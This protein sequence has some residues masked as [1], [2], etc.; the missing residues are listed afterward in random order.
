MENSVFP[1]QA[2]TGWRS[3]PKA[4]AAVSVLP[5]V[6]SHSQP[7]LGAAF[8]ENPSVFQPGSTTCAVLLFQQHFGRRRQQGSASGSAASLSLCPQ[9]QDALGIPSCAAEAV[10]DPLPV[11]F[12]FGRGQGLDVSPDLHDNPP[13]D[14]P[15]CVPWEELQAHREFQFWEFFTKLG[16]AVDLQGA[17]F[18]VK[19]C[20]HPL[21]M[22]TCFYF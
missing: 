16:Q 6:K 22:G 10:N 5:E 2:G 20:L 15:W 18:R 14:S 7:S 11:P 4:A 21:P 8:G 1:G 13:E 9:A 12:P 3:I 19:K 17:G